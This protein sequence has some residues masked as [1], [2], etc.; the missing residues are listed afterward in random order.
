MLKAY[1]RIKKVLNNIIN[2]QKYPD[3][4]QQYRD[5]KVRDKVILNTRNINRG[6]LHKRRVRP[7]KISYI[8]LISC[9]IKQIP[10]RYY[11]TF[12]VLLL[13]KY[14]KNRTH[15]HQSSYYH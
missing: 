2:I 3:F 11:L 10:E 13:E 7:F 12:H 5:F 4:N 15:L 6:K 9:N 8:E 1:I 14:K